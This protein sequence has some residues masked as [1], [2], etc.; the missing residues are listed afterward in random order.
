MS[1]LST[2]RQLLD[3]D[4]RVYDR[5]LAKA[6]RLKGTEGTRRRGTGHESIRA[7]LLHI[8]HVRDAWLNFV[9]RDRIAEFGTAFHPPSDKDLNSWTD[10]EEYRDLVWAGVDDLVVGLHEVDLERPVKAP[11]MAGEYTVRDAFFQVTIEQAHHLGEVIG[12]LW[13]IDSVPPDMTWIEIRR[14]LLLHPPN[15][16]TSRSTIPPARTPTTR[17]PRPRRKGPR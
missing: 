5:F 1:G 7:T 14:D 12:L 4:R 9:L 13:Q 8:L 2:V 3:Y 11:W 15:G 17:A 10:L 6:R 16:R